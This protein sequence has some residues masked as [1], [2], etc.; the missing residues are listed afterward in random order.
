[1]FFEIDNIPQNIHGY[2]PHLIWMWI[3]LC[4]I[5]SVPHNNVM[6]VKMLWL[7]TCLYLYSIMHTPIELGC[8]FSKSLTT[9][10]FFFS[11]TTFLYHSLQRKIYQHPFFYL[12]KK[13]EVC[14][15]C[16]PPCSDLVSKYLQ[17][18]HKFIRVCVAQIHP[19]MNFEKET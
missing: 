11:F 4:E 9:K 19:I 12:I 3:T 14:Y 13:I 6:D 10:F 16:K 15:C 1:M 18:Y 5:L 8:Q 7:Q 2:S 17:V